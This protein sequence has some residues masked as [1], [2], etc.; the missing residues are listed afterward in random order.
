MFVRA[1]LADYKAPRHVIFVET[2]GRAPNGK[3]DYRALRDLAIAER[4][5]RGTAA[6][7]AAVGAD[8]ALTRWRYS[9]Y[10]DRFLRSDDSSSGTPETF[11]QQHRHRDRAHDRCPPRHRERPAKN[12]HQQAVAEVVGCRVQAQRP[13]SMTLPGVRGIGLE[14]RELQVADALEQAATANDPAASASSH[15]PP[16]CAGEPPR[17]GSAATPPKERAL[18]PE[19]DQ[20]AH[21]GKVRARWLAHPRVAAVLSVPRVRQTRYPP[22]RSPQSDERATSSP[23]ARMRAARGH[24]A[25]RAM[26]ATPGP[27][28]RR[29]CWRRAARGS[30]AR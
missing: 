26:T 24:H 4:A 2:V 1:Q 21:P 12:P 27:R 7:E 19:H 22:R 10:P 17:A 8:S 9:S 28:R 29:R 23:C 30:R 25:T 11:H 5:D 3:L 6:A 16:G 15:R 14:A 13:R 18:Q 20:Q